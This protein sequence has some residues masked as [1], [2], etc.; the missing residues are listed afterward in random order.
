MKWYFLLQCP[1]PFP[2]HY[3]SIQNTS[4][5]P[6]LYHSFIFGKYKLVTRKRDSGNQY[7]FLS[8]SRFFTISRLFYE[9]YNFQQFLQPKSKAYITHI[10]YVLLYIRD[11][12]K[13]Y[14]YTKFTNIILVEWASVC[15][16]AP[17]V[18]INR[19]ENIVVLLVLF[20]FSFFFCMAVF[21]SLYL[22]AWL[23]FYPS[24]ASCLLLL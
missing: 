1:P 15:A 7:G 2:T 20:F 12:Y 9:K 3:S 13:Y 8:L 4:C 10:L 17:R 5:L 24:P 6:S 11:I 23:S 21:L 22:C 18:N 16:C 19:N 14:W